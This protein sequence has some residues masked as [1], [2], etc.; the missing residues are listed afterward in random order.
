MMSHINDHPP[1]NSSVFVPFLQLEPEYP[2]EIEILDIEAEIDEA[3]NNGKPI[4]GLIKKH[5][6]KIDSWKQ[7]VKSDLVNVR[8]KIRKKELEKELDRVKE[9][10]DKIMPHD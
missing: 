4:A 7:S 9:Y 1:L 5:Q 2:E 3:S 8:N 10:D 6:E